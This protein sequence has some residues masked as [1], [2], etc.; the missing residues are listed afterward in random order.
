M[1]Q[2]E[3]FDKFK[4]YCPKFA[5]VSEMW[6]P[7]GKNSIRVRLNNRKEVVFTFN[8]ELDWRFE[9]VESFMKSMVKGGIKK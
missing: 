8:S 5:E 3:V 7:N 6:F 2:R 9:T 4:F 1:L